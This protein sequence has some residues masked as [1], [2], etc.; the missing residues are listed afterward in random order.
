[1]GALATHRPASAGPG[2]ELIRTWFA[3]FV[4]TTTCHGADAQVFDWTYALGN[5]VHPGTVPVPTLH[6]GSGGDLAAFLAARPS[7]SVKLV[8]PIAEST[9][10]AFF[11]GPTPL[12]T[13]FSGFGNAGSGGDALTAIQ[14]SD[15]V[16]RIGTSLS[17]DALTGQFALDPYHPDATSPSPAAGLSDAAYGLA[18]VNT[19]APNLFS[20][21]PGFRSPASGD[22][23]APNV[24]SAL[25]TLPLIRLSEVA[26]VT[27]ATDAIVPFVARFN[28]HGG[29]ALV[30]SEFQG[31][32]AW[33][34]TDQ[35]LS[36]GD[37][38]ALLTHYR[39]R[40]AGGVIAH[41]G[42]VVGYTH[43]AFLDDSIDGWEFLRETYP[44]SL[45]PITL[46]TS[47]F[48]SD[49][50]AWSGVVGTS[51]AGDPL[52]TVLL[53]NLTD[54]TVVIEID[55]AI[56]GFGVEAF[57][58]SFR[59]VGPASHRL[60]TFTL[61]EGLWRLQAS[62]SA[63]DIPGDGNSG[64]GIGSA[65]NVEVAR[66]IP[67]PPAVPLFAVALVVALRGRTAPVR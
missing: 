2:A 51:N 56:D 42:G 28:L 3:A 64:I 21:S 35:L 16:H 14:V 55:D 4:L 41:T 5:P 49:G 27:P 24:R 40:G 6:D 50:T 43:E 45:T 37:Y 20:G 58:P 12:Q 60:L 19:A 52:A 11:D 36:R 67:L 31:Q 62:K 25:F 32:A 7:P 1:M 22:S 54:G 48:E 10:A 9:A 34:T 29:S 57:D 65:L 33:E 23:S 26:L 8:Q 18:G 39:M 38:Q 53:S 30:N 59:S 44:G 47:D 66:V 13:V 63:F 15:F 61:E 17:N 46:T